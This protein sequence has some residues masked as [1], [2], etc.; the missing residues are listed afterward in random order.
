M[1]NHT[2][3]SEAFAR[4]SVAPEFF[5]GSGGMHHTELQGMRENRTGQHYS[6]SELTEGVS[7]PTAGNKPESS[8]V[9]PH[10]G[11]PK[12]VS[13]SHHNLVDTECAV[14]PGLGSFNLVIT[15]NLE[16]ALAE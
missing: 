8:N 2:T 13:L 15:F 10:P 3:L 6:C 14:S 5:S 12:S 11:L 16:R 9:A 1:I 7:Q 4:A